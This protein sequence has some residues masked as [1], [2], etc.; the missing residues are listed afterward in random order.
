MADTEIDADRR[1]S[2][3]GLTAQTVESGLLRLTK[4]KTDCRD[5]QQDR[6][7]GSEF[8]PTGANTSG[9]AQPGN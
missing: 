2:E 4:T 6:D 7:R 1:Q 9:A 5:Q 8:S 3:W